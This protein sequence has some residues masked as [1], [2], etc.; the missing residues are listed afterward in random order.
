MISRTVP[1]RV[2][3]AM[4][5]VANEISP[6]QSLRIQSQNRMHVIDLGRRVSSAGLRRRT[7]TTRRKSQICVSIKRLRFRVLT[8]VPGRAHRATLPL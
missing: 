4:L 3:F 8:A 2:D 5:G 7:A 6:P 1:K